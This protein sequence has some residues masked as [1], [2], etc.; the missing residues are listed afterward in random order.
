SPDLSTND[1]VFTA[2]LD[3][4]FLG[5]RTGAETHA[6]IITVVES[7]LVPGLIWAGTDDG[8]VQVTRDAGKSWT[9]VRPNLPAAMVP[10]RTWVSRVEPSHFD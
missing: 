1:P 3:P 10:A 9:N 7:P 6:T 5:E 8:N 4:G 2:P